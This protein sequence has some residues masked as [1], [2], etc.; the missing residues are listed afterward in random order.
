ME[1]TLCYI[2][3][4]KGFYCEEA[5]TGITYNFRFAT[6]F[7]STQEALKQAKK[8]QEVEETYI[9]YYCIISPVAM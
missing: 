9:S 6:P 3:L 4:P 5:A 1:A 7:A 2:A 8:L